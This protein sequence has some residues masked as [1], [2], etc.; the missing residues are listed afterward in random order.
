MK[1][2]IIFAKIKKIVKCHNFKMI[3]LCTVL[4]FDANSL[5]CSGI[6]CVLGSAAAPKET[7]LYDALSHS[8]GWYLF[9]YNTRKHL[10]IRHSRHLPD[11]RQ[12]RIEIAE[13]HRVEPGL[14]G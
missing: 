6:S 11:D 1:G 7:S 4:P 2:D 9:S 5:V 10:P 14:P 13:R 12:F 3:V 8:T